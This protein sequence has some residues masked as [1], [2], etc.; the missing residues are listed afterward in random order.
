MSDAAI[1]ALAFVLLPLAFVPALILMM[2]AV[3]IMWACIPFARVVR[4]GKKFTLR[5]D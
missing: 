2:I 4:N 1:K 5:W 3:V